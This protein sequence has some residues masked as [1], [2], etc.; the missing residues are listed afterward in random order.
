MEFSSFR[1]ASGCTRKLTREPSTFRVAD[2]P[3]VG[4]ATQYKRV[5]RDLTVRGR[6][7]LVNEIICD[8]QEQLASP[9]CCVLANH[10]SN[11]HRA[12]CG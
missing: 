9:P 12:D 8:P 5:Y 2:H 1:N 7:L 10:A 3:E 6:D 11:M 4:W